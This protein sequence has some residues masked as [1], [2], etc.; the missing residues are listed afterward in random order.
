MAT[1]CISKCNI[2]NAWRAHSQLKNIFISLSKFVEL[3]CPKLLLYW[4]KPFILHKYWGWI[5]TVVPHKQQSWASPKIIL[6]PRW[7]EKQGCWE[8]D[9]F[10]LS[11]HG[12]LYHWP[13]PCCPAGTHLVM[14]GCGTLCTGTPA[15]PIWRPAAASGPTWSPDL[16]SATSRS[17]ALW[18][19][20]PSTMVRESWA[21]P[22][23]LHQLLVLDQG[24]TN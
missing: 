12:E 22:L 14:W 20:L 9:F 15:P 8:G 6:C 10:C 3:C 13:W 2:Y 7:F 24:W 4:K 11:F 21:G 16:Q 1:I 5:L 19:Q 18:L 23:L 17:T